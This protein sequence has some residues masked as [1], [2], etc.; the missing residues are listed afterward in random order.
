[1]KL[2]IVQ[3]LTEDPMYKM[4][5]KKIMCW[6]Q[7]VNLDNVLATTTQHRLPR[8]EYQQQSTRIYPKA[9]RYAMNN[10]TLLFRATIVYCV[11][12]GKPELEI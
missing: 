9:E 10:P 8:E 1:M 4:Y 11:W 5:A 3:L 2:L 12:F 6:Y 7:D